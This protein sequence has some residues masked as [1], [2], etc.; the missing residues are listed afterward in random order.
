MTTTDILISCLR[1]PDI[2]ILE[3]MHY[4]HIRLTTLAPVIP[5]GLVKLLLPDGKQLTLLLEVDLNTESDERI[6]EKIVTYLPYIARGS[7]A[8]DYGIDEVPLIVFYTP[9]EKRRD[10]LL[11]LLEKA[12]L[13]SFATSKASWF[14]VGSGNISPECFF[15]NIWITPA[16]LTDRNRTSLIPL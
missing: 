13:D 10:K 12:L 7:F 15:Q 2:H 4:F 3:A 1:I 11:S 6:K 8:K 9:E 5:D 16:G 14:L